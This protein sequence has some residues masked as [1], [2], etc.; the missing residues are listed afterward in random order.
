MY[1]YRRKRTILLFSLIFILFLMIVGYSVFQSSLKINGIS[2]VTSNWNIKITKIDTIIPS[3]SEA[4]DIDSVCDDNTS[5]RCDDGLTANIS[6]N[7][8]S[9]GDS[10]IYRIE[11]SNLGTL[12][13]VLSKIDINELS[14]SNVGFYINKNKDNQPVI[15]TNYRMLG[16]NGFVN[17]AGDN[18]DKGYVYFTIYYKDYDGQTSPVGDDK[19]VSS[20][21]SFIFGQKKDAT[22]A[23]KYTVTYDYNTHGG[24]KENETNDYEEGKNVDLSKND[25]KPGYNFIGWNTNK[26]ATTGMTSFNMPPTDVTLYAIYGKTVTITYVKDSEI[27]Q[28]G[29]I[30]D[31]CTM[32]NKSSSCSLTLP[33]ITANDNYIVDGWYDDNMKVGE[34]KDIYNISS[35]ITLTAK[36]QK[37]ADYTITFDPN[38]G[39]VSPTYINVPREKKVEQLPIPI[40]DGSNFG[41]WYTSLNGGEEID[42]D[43]IP[44]DDITVYARWYPAEIV[45]L[46]DEV[47]YTSLSAAINAVQPNNNLKTIKLIKDVTEYNTV[48]ENKNIIINLNGHTV[49]QTASNR[50]FTNNGTLE[51]KNGSMIMTGS[52]M[53]VV[54]NNKVMKIKNCSIKSSAASGAVDNNPGGNLEIIDTKVE[55]TGSRQA[56]YNDAGTL[57]IKGNTYLSNKKDRAALHNLNNGITTIESGTIISTSDIGGIYNQAGKVIIGV[58][59]GAVEYDNLIIQSSSYAIA[60]NGEIYLYDGILKGITGAIDNENNIAEIEDE[61]EKTYDSEIINENTYN[62]LY[63]TPIGEKHTVIFNPNGG[64]VVPQKRYVI[65]GQMIADLPIPTRYLYNFLGWYTE[66]TSGIEVT[67]DYIVED[68]M[69]IY[70]RWQKKPSYIVRFDTDGGN[71]VDDIELE[72]GDSIEKLPI[73]YKTGLVFDGWYL[74][75]TLETKVDNGYTPHTN[76]TLYAK[77]VEST[78]TK[79]FEQSGECNFNGNTSNITGSDC[80]KYANKTYIDTGISLYSSENINK[81]YEVSFEIVNYNPSDN[82]KQATLFNTKNETTGYPGLVFRKANTSDDKFEFASR[83]TS[84][85]NQSTLLNKSD[86]TKI[87]IYRISGEIYYSINDQDLIFSNDL[88]EY[89]PTFNLTAWFGAAPVDGTAQTTQRN[90]VGTLKNMYIKLGTF[91]G[92]GKYKVTYN[93]NGGT[94]LLPDYKNVSYGQSIGTLPEPT[95]ENYTFIGWY[96]SISSGIKVTSSYVPGSDMTIYAKW[97]P[98]T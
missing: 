52:S 62:T 45:A 79:V 55:M 46:I 33:S 23:A 92:F 4:T 48:A 84:S 7:L 17:K 29:K 3:E 35:D 54:Y 56:V 34:A 80:E 28:I 74:E 15:E 38:E 65:N 41:G 64:E 90:F 37:D 50:M 18:L 87:S 67:P 10:I 88:T 75:D 51:I 44:S 73:P 12:D 21:V 14:N 60:T 40:K 85:N 2:S 30:S 89:N 53:N 5:N 1:K 61:T 32:Y 71:E 43:Y 70:A 9:P 68:D 47:G 59:D 94:A 20:S 98:N 49:R 86:V 11:I 77:W 36:V 39:T 31:T 19:R 93:T 13:A 26:K 78:F 69:T 66:L 42:E 6:A 96:T 58:K 83:K 95:R 91:Q 82:V 97:I 72:Q 63:L 76:T 22:P 24:T 8:N 16:E 25:N 27:S 81:D 57:T